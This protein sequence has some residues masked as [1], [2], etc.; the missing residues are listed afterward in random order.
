MKKNSIILSTCLIT[1]ILLVCMLLSGCIELS[2]DNNN[3]EKLNNNFIQGFEVHEWGVFMY[4]YD[5]NVASF[6][7]NPP[8]IPVFYDKPVIYFHC[9]ENLTNVSVKV[10][11]DGDILVTIPDANL[12]DDGI[13]WVVDII[14]NS[15]IAPDGSSYDYLFYEGQM[16]IS[17]GV[18]AYA[19]VDG[20]NISFYVKNIADYTISDVFFVY[21]LPN[22]GKIYSPGFWYSSYRTAFCYIDSLK[23]GEL[24]LPLVIMFQ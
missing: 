7:T 14:N 19:I 12:T 9:D 4:D 24:L 3:M 2:Q 15:V 5:S 18:V 6:V 10:D 16:N 8:P 20:E 13:G 11:I 23:P 22:D 17:Q 21:G 1:F